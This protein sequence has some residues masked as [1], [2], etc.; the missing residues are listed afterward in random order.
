ML[1]PR[2]SHVQHDVGPQAWMLQC[3]GAPVAANVGDS[4]DPSERGAIEGGEPLILQYVKVKIGPLV[5]EEDLDEDLRWDA[6]GQR[7]CIAACADRAY[8]GE[9]SGHLVIY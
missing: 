7:E 8:H 4:G 3:N 9:H 1:S 5:V 6:A 2:A